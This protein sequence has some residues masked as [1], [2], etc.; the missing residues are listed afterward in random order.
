MQAKQAAKLSS[1]CNSW[2]TRTGLSTLCAEPIEFHDH[3]LKDL[4]HS[5]F[6]ESGQDLL[7]INE[8]LRNMIAFKSSGTQINNSRQ[9]E[10][11]RTVLFMLL[12]MKATQCVGTKS[13]WVNLNEQVGSFSAIEPGHA[14]WQCN[15]VCLR[16]I[17]NT[18]GFTVQ[19]S[20]IYS[21]CIWPNVHSTPVLWFLVQQSPR[22]Q[23]I[24][25]NAC[26]AHLVQRLAAIRV[27]KT[28]FVAPW[29]HKWHQSTCEMFSLPLQ[30]KCAFIIEMSQAYIQARKETLVIYNDTDQ[31]IGVFTRR[32]WYTTHLSCCS[33]PLKRALS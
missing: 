17:C 21:V 24:R 8:L 20:K 7:P 3:C 10:C 13:A 1:M 31:W 14:V 15:Q 23:V 5:S 30:T 33:V 11:W 19:D 25:G 16:K 29:T 12:P 27:S 18:A 22:A 4:K 6:S 2:I 32:V 9:G 26:N 28:S